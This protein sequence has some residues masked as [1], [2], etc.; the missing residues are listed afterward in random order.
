MLFELP[1]N[2]ETWETLHI[3]SGV[4]TVG[5]EYPYVNFDFYVNGVSEKNAYC[6]NNGI[7]RQIEESLRLNP[8]RQKVVY[9][10]YKRN[11]K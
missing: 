1:N 5:T 4:Y 6:S 8:E 3:T 10:F 2:E 9:F 7:K 11:S